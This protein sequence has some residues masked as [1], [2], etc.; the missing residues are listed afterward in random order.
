MAFDASDKPKND[1]SKNDD[2]DNVVAQSRA[3]AVFSAATLYR[4]PWWLIFLLFGWVY[5]VILIIQNDRFN[6]IYEQ[7]SR[8]IGLTLYMAFFSYFVAIIFGLI[9]GLIRA[10]PPMPPE[11]G[12]RIGQV[13]GRIVRTIIYNIATLYV[14][15][16]R[17]IPPI[18]FL[19]IAGFIVVPAIRDPLLEV[20]NG[21]IAPLLGE[22]SKTLGLDYMLIFGQG[23]DDPVSWRGRDPATAIAGLGLI[24]GAFLSE[25]FRAG[26]QS[27]E[28]GQVEAAKSL[29]MSYF[30]VMRY[31]V[32]PQA[33]RRMLP[34]LGNN[35]ISM[36]KDTS[37]VTVLGINEITQLS[38]KWAGSSFQYL[39]TYLVLS[40]L[41]LTLTVTGSLLVQWLERYLKRNSR[42]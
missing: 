3:R 10:T 30:Q 8:G 16:M 41:Y 38:R 42:D 37:L 15:F 4:A 6:L 24:Y 9:I 14:E 22:I 36:I 11:K 20:I 21:G 5:V 33:V 17:G 34:P 39:E 1:K 40:F 26:I 27:I 2:L 18:V 13:I 29:G 19:L 23:L 7:V 31:V 12:M 35:F 28:K 32:V 25:V